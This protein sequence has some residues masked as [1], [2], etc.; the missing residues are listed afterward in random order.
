MVNSKR[1]E[2]NVSEMMLIADDLYAVLLLWS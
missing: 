1:N 2:I